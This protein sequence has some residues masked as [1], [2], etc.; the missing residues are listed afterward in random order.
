MRYLLVTVL[1]LSVI[2]AL[3]LMAQT[4]KPPDK[5]VFQAKMGNVTYNHAA[6]ATRA[7]GDCKVCHDKL[8]KQSAKAP[9]EFK[10]GMHKPAEAA[11][12]SCGACHHAGG[13]AFESKG[14]CAKCH[15]K[16]S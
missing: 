15:V 3:T 14:N 7:K 2:G 1:A 10:A 9:L 4:P 8:F 12:T 16:A 6:H 5:L 13:T 11:K